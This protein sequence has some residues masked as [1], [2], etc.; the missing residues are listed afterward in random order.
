M[1]N[2]T[3]NQNSHTEGNTI[4]PKVLLPR[5]TILLL[6]DSEVDR[7]TY[8]RYLKSDLRYTYRIIEAETLEEGIEMWQSE[9]VNIALV[10]V[11][12]P[13]GDGLEFLEAIATNYPK[14]KLPVIVLTGV[15]DERVAVR[16]MKLGAADYLVKG[17]ITANLLCTC[18]S[19]VSVRSKVITQSDLKYAIIRNPLIVNPNTTVKDAITLMNKE[20]SLGSS[21]QVRATQEKDR[22]QGARSSCVLVVEENR[23]VGILTER[24]VVRL[25]AKKQPLDCLL[26]SQIM[27]SVV[28]TLRE[29]DLTDLFSAINLFKQHHIRHLP[30]LDDQKRIVGLLTHDSLRQVCQQNDLLQLPLVREVM[31]SEV[32]CA[33]PETSVLVIAQ[34]MTEHRISSVVI[35]E[36]GCTTTQPQQIPVGMLTERDL[37]KFQALD[38]NLENCTAEAVMSKP[39]LAIKPER[40]LWN[41]QQLMEEQNIRR[42]VVTGEQGELL[43]IITQT[44]VL[45]AI[46]PPE[47]H[48][49]MEVLEK[50]VVRLEAERV[51]LLEDRTAELEGLLDDRTAVLK[52]K[53]EQEKLLM[54]VTEQ[55]RSSLDLQN[56]LDTAVQEFRLLLQCHR[57]IVYQ[58]RPEFSDIVVAES[59]AE[60]ERSLLDSELADCWVTPEWMDQYRLGKIRVV[61]DLYKSD[62]TP[63]KLSDIRAVLVVPIIV[64]EQLWGLMLASH[65]HTYTWTRDGIDLVQRLSVHIAIAIQQA[66]AYQQMRAAKEAAEYANSA[67]S[68]FLALMSHEIRTPMNGILGL[69]HLVQQTPLQSNQRDYLKKIQSSA[70]SLLQIINDILDFSKIEAGKL[71]LEFILF[72]LDDILNSINNILGLKAAEKGIQLVFQVGDDVPQCLIGDSLRLTQVLMNLASNAVKFTETGFVTIAVE[73]LSCT[74]ETVRLKYQVQDTGMGIDRSQIERLFQSFTQVDTSISR[75]YGGTGLGLAICQGIVNMMGGSIGVESELGKGTT[76]HFELEFGYSRELSDTSDFPVSTNLRDTQLSDLVRL[77]EIQGANILLVEDNAINQQIVRELLQKV[78]LNVDCASNGKEA[79]AK[80]QELSYDLILMDIRMP[81][82][83]GLEATRLIRCLAEENNR[84]GKWFATVP[85]IAITANAMDIDRTK[86]LEVGMNDHLA[87]P[88]NPQRLYET[89]CKWI[90]PTRSSSVITNISSVSPEQGSLPETTVLPLPGLN[91]DLGLEFIGGDW[92]SYLEILKLVQTCKEDYETE[93]LAA[94]NQEDLT[95]ALHLVHSLKGLAGNIGAE[96]VYKYAASL[97]RELRSQTSDLE[98]LSTTAIILG[99]KFQQVLNSIDILLGSRK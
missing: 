25:G 2:P 81:E 33:T 32:V 53:V 88:I 98:F 93:I 86:S 65:R 66:K 90:V 4:K 27:K 96:T 14:D 39:I 12:L 6:D 80:V 67:K 24:D 54:T 31:N 28:I 56:I 91:V 23:V 5:I 85:I 30:I 8:I 77:E 1:S 55:I 44:N 94:I 83:D 18:V 47:V 95:K 51:K 82:I 50:Q 7:L 37:V 17:D 75:K 19:Q 73:L 72:E 59:I 10:D 34:L 70:Q 26:M 61:N 15:G 48:N 92:N 68:E 78:G 38:L 49:L 69:T 45:Q 41:V 58:F 52:A 71:E 79:I 89:L 20:R 60:G 64:E 13:D 84:E 9:E 74:D 57:A 40:S 97:E 11:N 3:Y 42:L 29:S 43:G 46:N 36:P 62:L 35:V 87:K 76:F 63:E 99:E 21:G 16:A 22:H